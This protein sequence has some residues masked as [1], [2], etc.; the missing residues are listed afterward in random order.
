MY[1]SRSGN[2]NIIASETNKKN[3]KLAGEFLYKL[4]G[5]YYMSS[6]LKTNI[7]KIFHREI[8]M[9]WDGIGEWKA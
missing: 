9:Y 4:G 6:F 1:K 3:L 7:P 5:C 8:D 2:G